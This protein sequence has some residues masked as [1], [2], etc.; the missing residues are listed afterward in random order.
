MTGAC[1]RAFLRF[2]RSISLT[3]TDTFIRA[4]G[5]RAHTFHSILFFSFSSVLGSTLGY[6]STEHEFTCFLMEALTPTL[7]WY[8]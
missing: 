6:A 1:E 7:A 2:P 5:K 8:Y 3:L 4:I